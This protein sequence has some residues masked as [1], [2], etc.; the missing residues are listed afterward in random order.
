MRGEYR[1]SQE[2]GTGLMRVSTIRPG[3]W[4]RWE[5]ELR[6]C[7]TSVSICSLI[8]WFCV[9]VLA[10]LKSIRGGAASWHTLEPHGPPGVEL[11]DEAGRVLVE[12]LLETVHQKQVKTFENRKKMGIWCNFMNMGIVFQLLHLLVVWICA[13]VK[14]LSLNCLIFRTEIT[15][16]NS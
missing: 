1:E 9:G 7:W 12:L 8:L 4:G 10:W 2:F 6:G 11:R 5:W 3:S 16:P 15:V 14:C 13:N